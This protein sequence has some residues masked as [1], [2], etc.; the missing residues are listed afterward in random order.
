MLPSTIFSAI[1]SYTILKEKA[2]SKY[3]VASTLLVGSSFTGFLG[4]VNIFNKILFGLL[5][6]ALIGGIYK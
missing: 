6:A 3:G 1:I 2:F 5:S 4:S